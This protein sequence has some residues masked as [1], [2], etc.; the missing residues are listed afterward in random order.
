MEIDPGLAARA[1][2]EGLEKYP[3]FQSYSPK[4]VA[5]ALFKGH[6]LMLEYAESPPSGDPDAWEFQNAVVKAYKRLA[7]S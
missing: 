4:L 7:S 5:R 2:S 3:R 1:L 6:A